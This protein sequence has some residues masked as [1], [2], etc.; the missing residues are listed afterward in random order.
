MINILLLY[1]IGVLCIFKIQHKL[2][3]KVQYHIVILM[4]PCKHLSSQLNIFVIIS[5]V[6]LACSRPTKPKPKS[7]SCLLDLPLDSLQRFISSIS[8]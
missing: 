7:N 5:R 6:G 4:F 8:V 2:I 3:L 1:F